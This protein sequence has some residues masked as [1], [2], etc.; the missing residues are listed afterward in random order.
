MRRHPPVLVGERRLTVT[1]DDS[2]S[3]WGNPGFEVLS[4][5]A[6]LGHVER[7]CAELL[8]PYLDSGELTVGVTVSLHHR[9]P[10]RVGDVV[11]I[12]ASARPGPHIEF[13]FEVRDAHG[14]VLCDGVHGRAALDAG[15]FRERLLR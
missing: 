5:P 9:A 13:Q 15:L 2:S 7:F 6:I 8:T 4:T 3:R 12:D 10:A 1:P 11:V 14:H